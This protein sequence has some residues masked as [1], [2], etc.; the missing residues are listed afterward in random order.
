MSTKT[1]DRP[2]TELFEQRI[3]AIEAGSAAEVV[4]VL[5]PRGGS[6]E[7]VHW[8]W[9]CIAAL[10]FLIV[11]VHSPLWFE[12]DFLVVNTLI[13]GIAGYACSRRFPPM[14]R[15]LTS[16]AR[17]LKQVQNFAAM[18]F[19]EL[20]LTHTR[21]RSGLLLALFEMEA[22][23]VLLP[24]LGLTARLSPAIWDTHR[25]RLAAAHRFPVLRDAALQVLTDLEDQLATAWPC[26]RE[27]D[28][29]ELSNEVRTL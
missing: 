15:L 23:A 2:S 4:V 11:A 17:R 20:Q 18:A 3:A 10:T 22:L 25:Q 5:Q 28:I 27:K 1:T 29:D 13:C 6:Y 24:D 9:A 14:C 16:R 12:P 8:K 7:D 19:T 26:E 21:E